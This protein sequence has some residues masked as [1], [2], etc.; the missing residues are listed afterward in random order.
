MDVKLNDAVFLVHWVVSRS[1]A[2]VGRRWHEPMT[3][4]LNNAARLRAD[5]WDIP[6]RPLEDTSPRP[7]RKPVLASMREDPSCDIWVDGEGSAWVVAG[8]GGRRCPCYRCGRRTGPNGYH[9][10]NRKGEPGRRTACPECV[11]VVTL[12]RE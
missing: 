3:A 1:V 8:Q 12:P 11:K 2:E 5:G 9:R 7:N 10:L 4:V 6:S